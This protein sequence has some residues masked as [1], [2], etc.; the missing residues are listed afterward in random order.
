MDFLSDVDIM[1]VKWK[2]FFNLMIIIYQTYLLIQN[3]LNLIQM[4][5]ISQKRFTKKFQIT[6]QDHHLKYPYF[7]MS[8]IN[9]HLNYF[10]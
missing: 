10:N 6:S 4:S 3:F 5:L 9:L 2:Y 7:Q 8:K 1:E